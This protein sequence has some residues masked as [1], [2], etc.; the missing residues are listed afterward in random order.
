MKKNRLFW[1]LLAITLCSCAT[2][3]RFNSTVKSLAADDHCSTLLKS[4]YTTI[5]INKSSD[6]VLAN[7]TELKPYFSDKDIL[8][9]NALDAVKEARELAKLKRDTTIAAKVRYIELKADINNKVTLALSE[10]S[11]VSAEINCE[12]DRAREMINYVDNLNAKRINR[13]WATSFV[14]GAA[15]VAAGVLIKNDDANN[16]V[17]IGAG[18]AGAGLGFMTLNAKGKKVNYYHK[19]NLLNDFWTGSE[20]KNFSPFVWYMLS[21]KKLGTVKGKSLLE[22]LR[23]WWIDAQFEGSKEEA[24]KSIVFS[25]G[26]AYTAADLYTRS[27]MINQVQSSVWSIHQSL[28][29]FLLDLN[30]ARF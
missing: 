1:L 27:S 26:G 25:E 19:T 11:S 4:Q 29:I 15:A 28:N 8:V 6:S 30:K 21:E 20:P 9:L 2:N 22:D 24:A 23:E 7:N 10:L 18:I 5:H 14:I 3:N 17:A 12:A 16:G 13:I